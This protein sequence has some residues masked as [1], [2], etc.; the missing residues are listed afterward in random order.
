MNNLPQTFREYPAV[1]GIAV[2]LTVSLGLV[3]LFGTLMMRSG[4]S[5]KPLVFFIGFLAIVG[6]PQAIVHLLDAWAHARAVQVDAA[7]PAVVAEPIG[8]TGAPP[9]QHP[10]AWDAVFGADADPALIVDARL[11]LGEVLRDAVEAR[12]AFRASGESAL[13]A[14]FP[15]A[16]SAGAALNRYGTFFQFAE[17]SGS[18][19][20]GWTARRFAGQGE[21]NH[22][23]TAGEELYAWTGSTRVAVE[24]RREGALGA[25]SAAGGVVAAPTAPSKQAVSTRLKQ[26]TPVMVAFLVINVA[27]ATG[28]FFKASAWS[29]RTGARAGVAVVDAG[30]LRDRLLELNRSGEPVSVSTG[31]DGRTVEATWRYGDARWFDLM[32]LHQ[33]NRT[34]R[35]V[36][37]FD[38]AA[39]VVRV[40]EYWSAFDASAGADGLRFDW[41]AATGIQFFQVEHK[42]VFGAQVE[43][44]GSVSG[45]L[46]A[47]YTFDLQ[48]LKAPLID[49]VTGAGWTWQPVVWQAPAGLRWLTE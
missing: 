48:S 14:R 27:L 16:E 3:V 12:I 37:S 44:D 19:A 17:V 34:H 23:V 40:R 35:L 41:R 47:A 20:A 8:P 15:S 38:E 18:D 42:R 36:L 7:R 39:R 43:S 45:R 32:R 6:G 46:S 5:L 25:L 1:A 22:V 26:N 33:M 4:A 13:A 2:F 11:S 31:A 10:V 21:W 28:W 29:A 30:V 9:V 49:A 24:S